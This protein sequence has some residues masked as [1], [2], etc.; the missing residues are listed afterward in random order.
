MSQIRIESNEI[1]MKL[2]KEVGYIIINNSD[3]F[4]FL[5]LFFFHFNITQLIMIKMQRK[6]N[7]KESK[8]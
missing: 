3:I 4:F 8:K 6:K 1:Q 2:L 5:F 7:E